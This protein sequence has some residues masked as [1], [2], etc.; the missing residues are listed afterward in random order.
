MRALTLAVLLRAVVAAPL[1]LTGY[2][3]ASCPSSLNPKALVAAVHPAYTDVIFAFAGVDPQG[4]VLNQYDA[5]SKNFTLTANVVAALKAKG[6]RVL[7]S[8]GGGAAAALPAPLPAGFAAT[9]L[10][11]LSAL[12]S[13][14]RL[15]GIDLDLENF[16]GSVAD[17]E[18]AMASI[19]D[20]V[21][22][23][24]AAHPGIIVTGAPQMT[25]LYCDYASIT[26]GFN[27]YAPLWKGGDGP[28]DYV[29]PQMYNSWSGVET[30]A[31]AL[32]YAAELVAGCNISGFNVSVPLP[33]LRLGYPASPSAAGS[34]YITPTAVVAMA[35]KAQINGLMTWEIGWD[36]QNNFAF[37]NAVAAG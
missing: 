13:S 10:A 30:I 19:G 24:R 7:L 15:D 21:S 4:A 6:V 12:V 18:A 36:A 14:L 27:R 33:R 35:R 29:M 23:L 20:V 26:A 1:P 3:C 17:I 5:P 25:D 32:T 8:V 22:G 28:L 11:G 34:G 9:L 31:Y 2:F 16:S 37:A